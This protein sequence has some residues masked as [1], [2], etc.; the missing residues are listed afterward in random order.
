MLG[1][2]V[3]PVGTGRLARRDILRPRRFIFSL[4]A[5]ILVV[6]LLCVAVPLLLMGAYLLAQT[7]EALE[8]KAQESLIRHLYARA[9]E[10]TEWM[11]DRLDEPARWSTSFIAYDALEARADGRP[12]AARLRGELQAYLDD[13][14]SRYEHLYESLFVV[15]LDGQVVVGSRKE[16]LEDWVIASLPRKPSGAEAAQGDDAGKRG[17]LTPMRA[18]DRL[19]RPTLLALHR[20]ERAGRVVGYFVARIDTRDLERLLAEPAADGTAHFWLLDLDQRV[21]IGASQGGPGAGDRFAPQG[22]PPTSI[23][24]VQEG[25]LPGIGESVYGILPLPEKPFQGILAATVPKEGAYQPLAEARRRLLRAGIPSVFVIFLLAYV[26]ARGMLRPILLLSEG[27]QRVSAGDLDVHL[28]VHGR[29]ELADLTSAFNEMARRVRDSRDELAESATALARTND[30]LEQAKERFRSQA[31]TDAL[32]G[33]FNRRHFE[34]CLDEQIARASEEG[35]PLSLLLLDLDHFKQF[36]D[37]WGHTEGD[38]ELRR[39]AALLQRTVRSTDIAFRYG[40]EELA[41][42]LPACS[43]EQAMVVAEKVRIAVGSGTQRPS[44]FGA[45]TTVSAGV[46]TYPADGRVARGL[47]DTADAAL[48]QAKAQGRDRVVAAGGPSP[49]PLDGERATG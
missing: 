48:Y 31:I 21:L 36:N 14:H 23:A 2:S 8:A 26:L 39:V 15:D 34:D 12:N 41:V 7:Q 43:K 37:R 6:V 25:I 42:L 46:A 44:R 45:R 4:K 30:Q 16:I 11:K 13:V 28:P 32:T 3:R 29:D 9:G 5:K 35:K 38:A 18:A 33:I 22:P 49:G 1:G 40:G 10:V 24:P 17:V 19:A 47:V 27:A 20:I